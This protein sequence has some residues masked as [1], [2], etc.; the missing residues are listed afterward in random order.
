MIEIEKSRITMKSKNKI[1]KIEI[2]NIKLPK[3]DESNI[4][5]HA[6]YFKIRFVLVLQMWIED[7]DDAHTPHDFPLL[8]SAPPFLVSFLTDRV[9]M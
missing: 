6:S 4:S 5:A 9:Q 1:K 7:D 3:A 8:F 2:T